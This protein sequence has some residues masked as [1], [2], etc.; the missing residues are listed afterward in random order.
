MPDDSW[1]LAERSD[2][3][4]LGLSDD[5]PLPRFVV[6]IDLGTT[7]S[8]MAYIDTS[9]ADPPVQTVRIPQLIDWGSEEPRETLPSFYYQLTGDELQ[10]V[11]GRGL[12]PVAGR[13]SGPG[14]GGQAGAMCVV[15]E[16]ARCQGLRQPG[17]Q[18]ASA[19]SWLSHAGVDR[20]S[21]ILPWRADED[22]Q[23]LSPV[24]ASASYLRHLAAGWNRKFPEHP[25]ADQ[26][27]VLT[28]PASFDETARRLTVEAAKLAG[29][30][31]VT[32]IE[33]PQAA[34]YAWLGRNQDSYQRTILP[35]QSILVC[36][37]GGGTT[38]FTLI[39]V[40]SAQIVAGAQESPDR[41]NQSDGQPAAGTTQRYR[42]HRVAVGQ[43]LILG[44]DNL[45]L[46]IAR[47]AESELLGGGRSQLPP[48][49]W[50]I[51]RQHAKTAKETLLGTSP[52]ASYTIHLPAGGASLLAGARQVEISAE[53]VQS[54][55]LDGFFPWVALQARPQRAATG[56]QEFGLPYAEDP[57]ITRHLA[58]F[59]WQH[60]WDGRE[61]CEQEQ[62]DEVAAACPDWILFNGGVLE[63][64]LIRQRLT[65]QLRRWFAG[66]S[67]RIDA[68]WQ[69]GELQGNRL[70]L[71]VAHGAACFGW[72]QRGRGLQIESNLAR[73]YY[74]QISA[75]P[76]Q[77]VCLVP[78]RASA[79][80]R[81]RLDQLPLELEVG[82]PV[83]LPLWVS[84][85]HLVDRPGEV[86]PVDTE[87]MLPM[88]A[89]RTVI[90]AGVGRRRERRQLPVVLE[91]T[92]S[93]IGTLELACQAVDGDQRWGLEFDVRSSVET[94]RDPYVG[95]SEQS[96]IV[97]SG[98]IERAGELLE[99]CFGEQPDVPPNQL[100]DRLRDCFGMPRAAW[101]PSLLRGIW[102]CLM[103]LDAGRGHSAAHEARWLNLA[104]FTLRPGFGMAAD[105]WRVSQMWRSVRGG[106]RHRLVSC[107]AEAIILWRRI[108]GGF[109]AGQQLALFQE[110]RGRL[111]QLLSGAGR[112]S[113]GGISTAEG[114]ELLRL[115]GS[116]ERLPLREKHALGGELLVAVRRRALA[117]LQ[118]A[119]FWT[120]GRIGSRLPIYGP[121]NLVVAPDV[122]EQWLDQLLQ[123]PSGTAGAGVSPELCLAAMLLARRTGDRYRDI[124]ETQRQRVLEWL[125]QPGVPEN[126]LRLVAEPGG[127]TDQQQT[128]LLGEALPLGIRIRQ[129]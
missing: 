39:R 91:A 56:F 122:A 126:Y 65:E 92:L 102:R 109:T 94:D 81:F 34:F 43:H 2:A 78:G 69:V 62:L 115:I 31:R 71:A 48:R 68:A 124:S 22:V 103:E 8:A 86:V 51:L 10:S 89:I 114:V 33:E 35:G 121:L 20:Q 32:L 66:E 17:R 112:K 129:S 59:L 117:D 1:L 70:D 21:A 12:S 44:G 120:L 26:Q 83:A 9:A 75:D 14:A 77:V 127:L 30:P 111:K 118:P 15:G 106:L 18:I 79:G 101:P 123:I 82:E 98:M 23:P 58:D 97:D 46:A 88:P 113:A 85:R 90:E 104:G 49:Q 108:A 16:L 67:P 105:D 52:P 5:A 72:A 13:S 42:L 96:G 37:I 76:P 4:P 25:L 63:S 61:A 93:Q 57:A 28:L 60:R 11:P 50:D 74:L 95:G 40:A 53:R 38:D 100:L 87:R 84:S 29:L 41:S 3:D 19:K 36:D 80:D 27:V 47:L 54:A 6:G 125:E 24:E 73:A 119:L 116:L 107:A 55:L 99:R 45:D 7:N 64:P 110:L 128:L